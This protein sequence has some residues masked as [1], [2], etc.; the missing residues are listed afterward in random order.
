M[1][2]VDLANNQAVSFRNLSNAV[3]EGYFIK[4]QN[5]PLTDECVT[6]D[7]ALAYAYLNSIYMNATASN[8]LPTKSEFVSEGGI[9]FMVRFGLYPTS[10]TGY[11]EGYVRLRNNSGSTIYVYAYYNSG[12]ANS[13]TA[14]GSIELEAPPIIATGSTPILINSTISSY[15]QNIYSTAYYA[16]PNTITADLKVVKDDS[17]GSGSAMRLAYSTTVG[18]TKITL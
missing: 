14:N 9:L 10:G 8:G 13:G 17:I 2:W 3:D 4:K 18:G 6:K 5:I 12:G 11:Q 1:G 7:D 16:I 15:G